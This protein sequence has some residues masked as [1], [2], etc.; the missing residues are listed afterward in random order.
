MQL[1]ER[2]DEL[3]RPGGRKFDGTAKIRIDFRET[4]E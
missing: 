2:E 3:L 1:T 4:R